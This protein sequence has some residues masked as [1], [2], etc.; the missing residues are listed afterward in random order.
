[1]SA[2]ASDSEL[3]KRIGAGDEQAFISLYHRRQS[4]VYRFALQMSG[5]PS[6]AEDVTQEVFL[7]LMRDPSGYDEARGSVA[8]Y[9][10]G[11]ARNYVLRRLD[12]ESRFVA[13]PEQEVQEAELNAATPGPA[14]D[15]LVELTR[16]AE[17]E[18]VRQAILLLP[19]RYREVVVLCDLHEMS[20]VEAAAALDCALGTIRSRLHRARILLAEKLRDTHGATAVAKKVISSQRSY[21]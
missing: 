19:S 7:L 13:L 1:L 18:A 6:V 8:A 2:T 10:Y 14:A 5:S 11:V 21:A 3:L 9:L 16:N 12:K 4:G 15:P 20:Y 17:I